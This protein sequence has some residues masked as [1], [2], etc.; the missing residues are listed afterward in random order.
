M[1]ERNFQ[2]PDSANVV[3]IL[4]GA[5]RDV[6]DPDVALFLMLIEL[7]RPNNDGLT[8]CLKRLVRDAYQN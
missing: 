5:Y 2:D 8:P 3:D 4:R 7:D 1:S 6:R